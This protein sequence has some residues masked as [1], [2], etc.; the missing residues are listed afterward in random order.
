MKKP[1]YEAAASGVRVGIH[2]SPA[3]SG[4]NGSIDWHYWDYLTVTC[5]CQWWQYW[6]E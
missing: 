4:W 5:H 2:H 6:Y 3:G 1:S